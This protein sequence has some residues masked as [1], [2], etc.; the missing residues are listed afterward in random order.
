MEL[1]VMHHSQQEFDL[2]AKDV[3]FSKTAVLIRDLCG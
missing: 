1:T 2:V 3:K